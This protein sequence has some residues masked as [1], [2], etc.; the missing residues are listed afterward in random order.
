MVVDDLKNIL[1]ERERSIEYMEEFLE[2][3]AIGNGE[4]IID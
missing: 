4:I 2:S 3:V 1:E